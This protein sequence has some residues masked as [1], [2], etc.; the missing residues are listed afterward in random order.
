M[1]VSSLFTGALAGLGAAIPMTLAMEVMHRALPQHERYPLPPR[2]I[3]E[4]LIADAGLREQLDEAEHVGLSLLSHF[5]YG[6]AAGAVYATLAQKYTLSPL[7]G[8]ITF[9]LGLWIVSYLGWVPAAGILRPAIK[10]PPR[11]N[12]LMLTAHVIWGSVL[13]LLVDRF[14]EQHQEE[15]ST[16]VKRDEREEMRLP[17]S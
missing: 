3:T 12:A 1:P 5:S 6:A 8:G 14:Q 7:S 15:F 2:E 4:K 9:G 10:H 11:R 13:G 17:P 16:R